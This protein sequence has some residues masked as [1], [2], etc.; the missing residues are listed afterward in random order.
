[1]IAVTAALVGGAAFVLC[2][3]FPGLALWILFA[4]WLAI[5][6]ICVLQLGNRNPSTHVTRTGRQQR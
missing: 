6:A 4:A 5:G 3:I 1:M 2:L